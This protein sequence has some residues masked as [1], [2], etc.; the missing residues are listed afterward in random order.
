ME[1]TAR[2]QDMLCA[3]SCHDAAELARATALDLDF[4]V[5][6]PVAPTP[7]HPGVPV[8]GWERFASIRNDNAVPVY[9]LGG[10]APHDLAVAQAHGAHGL[11]MR[12]A[13]WI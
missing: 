10:L 4:G 11:A 2:P 13:L 9:A 5:L 12:S 1:A 6:G 7:S 8:L 3:A